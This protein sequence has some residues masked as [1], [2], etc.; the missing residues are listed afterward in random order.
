MRVSAPVP[1]L[2]GEI[3]SSARSLFPVPFKIRPDKSQLDINR[4]T[5]GSYRIVVLMKINIR[6]GE[7]SF[8]SDRYT[9]NNNS[10]CKL[11]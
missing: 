7:F 6:V 5:L 4:W 1:P 8:P 10:S 3:L 9:K 11:V 2:L